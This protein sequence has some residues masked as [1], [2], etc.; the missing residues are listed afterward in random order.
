M[1]GNFLSRTAIFLLFFLALSA[2]LAANPF[3]GE[4]SG[5]GEI[6]VPQPAPVRTGPAGRDLVSGQARLR[7]TLGSCFYAWKNSESPAV[8]WGIIGAAFLY[9][10]LHALGPGHRKT[11]IFSY[12]LAREAPSWEPAG[13]GFLLSLL[14]GGASVVLFLIL[15]GVSGAISGRADS[16]ARTMEGG[17]YALLILVALFLVLGA[18]RDLVRGSPGHSGKAIGLGTILLTGT[19]P[20]PGAILIL[21]LSLTLEVTGMGMLAVC[22]MSLGMGVPIITAGYLAWFGRSG[23]FYALKRNEK[24]IGRISA[25]IE[26]V[27][28]SLLL[29]F[30]VYIAEPFLVSIAKI[31][32]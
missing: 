20:C 18:I 5:G 27:G 16:I 14:H 26:L 11:V 17:A 29:L 1:R 8:F 10:V 30:A 25:G 32:A 23:L 15:R 19:Y 24:Q 2:P 21:V 28:Y 22:S 31:I 7:E 13:L 6:S 12:Y 4:T 3:I 9:G